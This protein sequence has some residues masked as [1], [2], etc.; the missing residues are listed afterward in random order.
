VADDQAAA[1]ADVEA[2]GQLASVTPIASSVGATT[3]AGA[4]QSFSDFYREHAQAMVGVATLL[5]GSR[6]EAEEIVQDAFAKVHLRWDRVELPLAY[7]RRTVVNASRSVL[8]RRGVRERYER[9]LVPAVDELGARELVDAVGHLP[10][11]QRAAVVLR[12]YADLSERETA[13]ALGCRPGT[14]GSLVSR[15]MHALRREIER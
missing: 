9:Q 4:P 10:A 8:R 13:E 7:T 12:F 5:V 15:A 3:D 1:R 2:L 6:A 14:V 11:R